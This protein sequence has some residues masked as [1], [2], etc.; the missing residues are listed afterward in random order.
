MLPFCF[1]ERMTLFVLAHIQTYL[2]SDGFGCCTNFSSYSVQSCGTTFSHAPPPFFSVAFT[3][4][5]CVVS[6]YFIWINSFEI[7]LTMVAFEKGTSKVHKMKIKQTAYC[8][9]QN[10]KQ[11]NWK[12]TVREKSLGKERLSKA[13]RVCFVYR[14]RKDLTGGALRPTLHC[15][16]S[17]ATSRN[18]CLEK[19][20][21][22]K[23][24]RRRRSRKL[25]K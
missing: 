4:G 21:R 17:Y 25:R 2:R 19:H 16:A 3:I 1:W 15:R 12:E 22:N 10:K 23:R 7:Q 9:S 8:K 18:K 24:R 14:H 5:F 6:L 20:K 11:V 13:S